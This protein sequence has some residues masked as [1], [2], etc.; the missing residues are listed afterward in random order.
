M[1]FLFAIFV[2]LSTSLGPVQSLA[3]DVDGQ[4][5]GQSWPDDARDV[6]Y[7]ASMGS[8]LMPD[9]WYR[10]LMRADDGTPF[11]ARANVAGYGFRFCG[12]KAPDPI[13][14][15]LDKD[16]TRAPAIG[17]TCAACHTGRLTDGTRDFIV[18]GGQASMDLQGFTTDLFAAVLKVRSGPYDSAV[19]TE[20]WLAFAGAVLGKDAAP[21][22][23]KALHD[24]VSAW[25]QQRKGVQGSIHQGGD[26][27]YG[28][29]DVV[30]MILN[31]AARLSDSQSDS[32]ARG[33]LPDA[34]APVSIPPV[35]LTANT[36]QGP[37]T[38]GLADMDARSA[39]MIRDV[40]KVVGVFADVGLA[41]AATPAADLTVQSSVRLGN[42]IRLRLA[43]ATL[44]PPQWP[45]E[46]GV[47]DRTS[48]D[49]KA[50]AALY[51]AQC[52]ACHS[53]IDRANP[54]QDLQEVS[55]LAPSPAPAPFVRKVNAFFIAKEVGPIV[56]TDPM[57]VCNAMTHR[58][59]SGK[60][61]AFTDLSGTLRS[62][63]KNGA[64]GAKR[65]RFEP[66]VQT[67]RLMADLSLRILW[68]KRGEAAD[69]QKGVLDPQ[70]TA[71]FAWLT[72]GDGQIKA[73]AGPIAQ[74]DTA[75]IPGT[76][77]LA[78]LAAVRKTCAAQL[79]LLR[80]TDPDARTP[81]YMAGP[82]AGIFATAPYLH[83]G[84][85]PTLDALLQPPDAR[86]D[87]FTVGAVRFDPVKV[88]LGAAIDGAPQSVFKVTNLRGQIIAGHANE[89]HAF[90]STPLTEMQRAQLILYLK[91]L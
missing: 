58:S 35:W 48:A 40:S 17:L 59:W 5:L 36:A 45:K 43:L 73:D 2:V 33:G 52:A 22:A 4:G 15:V 85:V 41:D 26:W 74:A 63:L 60:M 81:G 47:I 77:R 3:C 30:Q 76:H 56:G 62:Y 11:A 89:G 61:T 75:P 83:N 29:L 67:L 68:D 55:G 65:H 39:A 19:Q 90:P 88:G 72:G 21:V 1:R 44:T 38:G 42:L 27:G 34:S 78:D 84:S 71:F 51:D 32:P 50:G 12:D 6:W 13:G 86:P 7:T 91:G 79:A 18:H 16:A 49:Y 82:L 8:R 10:A 25:L 46:W 20:D 24:D 87:L 31:T 9:T 64:A 69:G 70:A 54:Q 23:T 53:R 57:A 28:R 37:W 14:F 66:G 80:Q